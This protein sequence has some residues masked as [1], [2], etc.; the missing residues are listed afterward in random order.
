M[1]LKKILNVFPLTW[2]VIYF[3]TNDNDAEPV[4]EGWSED[5]PYWLADAKI[6]KTDDNRVYH[7]P[8]Q[9]EKHKQYGLV[10]IVE[11]PD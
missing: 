8:D 9:A 7:D 5:V 11:E 10:L 3:D 4:Y 2:V 1:K 6:V